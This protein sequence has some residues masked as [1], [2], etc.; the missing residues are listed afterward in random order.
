METPI[1][2]FLPLIPRRCCSASSMLA[3]AMES[4]MDA[5]PASCSRAC[6]WHDKP[7]HNK[8][9][10]TARA[11]RQGGHMNLRRPARGQ[12]FSHVSVH[13]F[14]DAQAP[15]I[16]HEYAPPPTSHTPARRHPNDMTSDSALYICALLPTC[17]RRRK[18][19]AP[20]GTGPARCACRAAL[21]RW[22]RGSGSQP[23][24][25]AR[26]SKELPAGMCT[27]KPRFG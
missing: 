22:P 16:V 6:T 7:S 19:H 10:M 4:F 18:H 2:T 1:R 21:C 20:R 26:R 9:L 14:S 15:A 13:S 17:A 3:K 11:S 25:E 12:C 23:P 27:S 5:I 8:T 24:A